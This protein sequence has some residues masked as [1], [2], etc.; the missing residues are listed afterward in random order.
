MLITPELVARK[1]TLDVPND[2]GYFET[3]TPG[4]GN[5]QN[6]TGFVAEPIVQRSARVLHDAAVGRPVDAHAGRH[7]RLHHQRLDA[8][9]S[10]PA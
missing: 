2:L 3:P 6:L 1:S 7:H 9:A 8:R 4:Y 10:T 5:G